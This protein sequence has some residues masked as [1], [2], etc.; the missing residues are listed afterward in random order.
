MAQAQTTGHQLVLGHADAE[1]SGGFHWLSPV[2][3][4]LSLPFVATLATAPFLLANAWM[5][6]MTSC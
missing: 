4:G 2:L 6:V 5:P 3:I 1:A